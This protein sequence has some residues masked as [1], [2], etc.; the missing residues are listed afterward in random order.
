MGCKGT[1]KGVF[2]NKVSYTH[3]KITYEMFW[4]LFQAVFDFR[5]SVFLKMCFLWTACLAVTMTNSSDDCGE[6]IRPECIDDV[7]TAM[8]KTSVPSPGQNMCIGRM[9]KGT[10]SASQKT[11]TS[12]RSHRATQRRVNWGLLVPMYIMKVLRFQLLVHMHQRARLFI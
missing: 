1:E 3:G 7:R 4:S 5:V 2:P 10:V 8:S 12:D 6:W 9:G 11:D